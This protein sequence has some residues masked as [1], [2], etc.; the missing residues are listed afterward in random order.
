[1]P[2]Y[3]ELVFTAARAWPWWM[4]AQ[5][6]SKQRHLQPAALGLLKALNVKLEI[7][8]SERLT[9]LEPSVIIPLHEGLLDPVVLQA[10]LPHRLRFMVRD[11]FMNWQH[12]GPLL[13]RF[14]VIAICPERPASSLRSL[15][16]AEIHADEHLVIFAQGSV[17]GLEIA[18]KS[19][20]FLSAR[21]LG[22]AIVPVVLT[23][24]HRIWEHPFS[25][26]LRTHQR[27]S[28]RVL[29]PISAARVA[30]SKPRV[31]LDEVQRELKRVALEP[32][33]APVRRYEPLRDGYWLGYSFDIDDAFKD[34]QRDV[35]SKRAQWKLER[36]G[37]ALTDAR[38]FGPNAPTVSLDDAFD[39]HQT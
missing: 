8:G 2:S 18:L 7:T 3:L 11:E 27:V 9:G 14:N 34:L 35:T 10:A 31:L 12:L 25:P 1:M 5:C 4:W 26:R 33:M 38:A 6:A 13:R 15:L 24:T 39:D 19:G 28:L 16:R 30:S 20:A 32:E 29:E 36:E 17:L 37:A 23:G 22:R 21:A